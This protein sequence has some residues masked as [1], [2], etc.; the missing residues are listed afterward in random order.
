MVHT[1]TRNDE[2]ITIEVEIGRITKVQALSRARFPYQEEQM[3]NRGVETWAERNGFL[4]DGV[5][6]ERKHQKIMGIPVDQVPPNHPLRIIYPSK[7][8]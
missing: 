6:L 4:F 8:R 7:F 5:D 2:S 3:Y 1:L